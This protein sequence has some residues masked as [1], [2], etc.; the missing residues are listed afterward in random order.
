MLPP[1]RPPAMP[2]FNGIPKRQTHTRLYAL[3]F[4]HDLQLAGPVGPYSFASP[5]CGGFAYNFYCNFIIHRLPW[6]ARVSYACSAKKLFWRAINAFVYPLNSIITAHERQQ[7]GNIR[8]RESCRAVYSAFTI[9]QKM[10]SGFTPT[11]T[12]M[13]APY[14][15]ASFDKEPHS[16]AKRG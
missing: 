7:G 9:L 6:I 14:Y 15:K 11:P 8:Y 10:G 16:A 13:M 5:P 2:Y 4:F 3:A 1:M 12:F